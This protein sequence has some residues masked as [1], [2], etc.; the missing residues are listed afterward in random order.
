MTTKPNRELLDDPRTLTVSLD[1]TKW[2]IPRL[3]PAQNERVTPI[4]LRIMPLLMRL[5]REERSQAVAVEGQDLAPVLSDRM[6]RLGEVLSEQNL[7]DIYTAI[8]VALKKGHPDLTRD[9]FD[10]IPIGNLDA[11]EAMNVI[12]RQT[13][14]IRQARPGETAAGEARAAA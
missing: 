14:T 8:Y 3:A 2:P 13:G 1:G 6:E 12:A 4:I 5:S 7:H 10:E 11:I 9:E